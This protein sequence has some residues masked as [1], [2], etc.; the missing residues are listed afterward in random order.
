[1]KIVKCDFCGK[2]LPEQGN[3]RTPFVIADSTRNIQVAAKLE[4]LT[5]YN[6]PPDQDLYGHRLGYNTGPKDTC[7]TCYADLMEVIVKSL[8]EIALANKSGNN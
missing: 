2:E 1:M 3:G 6:I 8:R 4:F 5:Q 7:L